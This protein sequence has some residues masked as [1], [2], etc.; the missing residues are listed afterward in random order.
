[1]GQHK[2]SLHAQEEGGY[3]AWAFTSE[4]WPEV[5]G[6]VAQKS[7]ASITWRR[8]PPTVERPIVPAIK[9][10]IPGEDPRL[11]A[12]EP[13]PK[14][15]EATD[16]TVQAAPWGRAIYMVVGFA[17]IGPQEITQHEHVTLFHI[18]SLSN[19]EHVYVAVNEGPFTWKGMKL[20]VEP[21][22]VPIGS[23][24]DK[25]PEWPNRMRLTLHGEDEHGLNSV[26][27]AP[28]F[29]PGVLTSIGLDET[30]FLEFE[31]SKKSSDDGGAG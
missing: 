21:V 11:D 20:P 29:P 4:F 24:F 13:P 16:I 3:S 28:I 18:A 27:D 31:V 1:M 15:G 23:L 14:D 22:S 10:V 26:V 5:K 30:R 19:G 9:I 17:L 12:L 6:K 25:M 8:P 7:R 2:L